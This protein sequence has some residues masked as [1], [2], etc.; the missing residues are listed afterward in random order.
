MKFFSNY[1]FVLSC[2]L[3]IF[4]P[5]QSTLAQLSVTGT[6]YD[7]ETNEPLES[8][9]IVVEGTLTGTSTSAD[10]TFELSVPSE[11][12]VLI[13]SFI[14]FVTQRLSVATDGTDLNIQLVPSIEDIEG[15][16]VVGTRR[17]PRLVTDSSVPIDVISPRDLASTASTD[18]DDILRSQVPSYNVQRHEIDGS[19]TFV[20]PPTLRGLSPD[21]TLLLVNGKR[22]HRTGSIALFGSAL[23][24]GSQGP[25]MNMIPSIAIKQ[26][27]ILRDGASA[28]YGADAV[29]GVFNLQLKDADHGFMVRSQV[30]Q[31]H[32][33]DGRYVTIASNAGFPLT[34]DGFLN[35]SL[36]Y[37]NTE[38]TSRSVDQASATA[39]AN[40]GYPV[41]RPA[42]I[43]GNP[44]ID[45]A[46]TA[47]VNAEIGLTPTTRA[48]AFGGYGQR[49]GNG[50]YFFRMP[51]G[52]TARA[53]VFR[54][55]SGDDAIRAIADLNPGD[56]IDCLTL[57]DLP[58][59]D[60]DFDAVQTFVNQYQGSCY[61][62]N[63]D[64][65]GGFTP[66]FGADISDVSAVVGV[67]GGD[68]SSLMWDISGTVGRS[69]MD[70]FIKNT[71]NASWGPLNP[72]EFRQRDFV[73]LEYSVNVDMSY[74]VEIEG[75]HS[76]LNIA[77][78]AQWRN[79]IFETRPGD[80]LSWSVGPYVQ[81]G[82]YTFS[83][84]SNGDQGIPPA[85]AGRWA[86]PNYAAY[87]DLEADVVPSFQVGVAGRFENFYDDF[88]TTLT[89]KVSALWRT[90]S[91]LSLR[92][93]VST[94]VR[95]PTPGQVNLQN[96]QTNFHPVFGLIDAGQIPSAH[97]IAQAL[98][99]KPLTEESAFNLT[100]GTI[101]QF[102]PDLVLTADLFSITVRDRIALSGSIPLSDELTGI[103]RSSGQ[104]AG[105][106]TLQEVKFYS[107]D[108]D[109]RQFGVDLLLSWDREYGN[110]RSTV[111]SI[112]YNW[113]R[114][115]LLKF[116]D[117]TEITTF[118][119]EPLSEATTVSI[120]S[121]RRKAEI[122]HVN[123]H[124][125]IV[126]TGRQTFGPFHT[127]LR[128]NY[129]SGW[130]ACLLFSF[131][132]TLNIDGR[133]QNVLRSYNGSWIVD[134][135]VGY[136]IRD[137]YGL[138]LGV[139]NIFATHR[140]ADQIERDG[141]GNAM[142]PSTPWDY[143]GASMYLRLSADF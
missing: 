33:G 139:N 95:A 92:G 39:L 24:L 114:P 57:E 67:H 142:V 113:T 28:Q 61:L 60:S 140:D 143:N 25:D 15:L 16:V 102:S 84:G 72:P 66:R 36:E 8:V 3:F 48:Y 59:L 58:P 107:N 117:P 20:R 29:A 88:G 71:V 99:G 46:I 86:R 109:T 42:I 79:E 62:F 101:F 18:I 53:N 70:Y 108:F 43:W 97:P 14:G 69:L 35:V 105:F 120:L 38:P 130:K 123:P 11:D 17:L 56:G 136:R 2:V 115:E 47:F 89:G 6:V 103:L 100:F 68:P 34:D 50:S 81:Q 91:L 78:G 141:Q 83:V 54:F 127:M 76:P 13:V 52:A 65:P 93:S 37:R 119:G 133:T 132:C 104:L 41:K 64:F 128:F 27:E 51:G 49:S 118:L 121:D 90:S 74:P 75:L 87:V 122:E 44:D 131:T 80:S 77:M 137:N 40:K 112:A 125:R 7:S 129:Y 138:A 134:A 12:A 4:I 126:A 135:E 110:G 96:I 98:G 30:G 82:P 26:F 10:G 73:Q 19:T 31:Y 23:I 116:S 1:F 9:T 106:E 32:Q 22:R 21:N 85:Y 63:E 94:G 124:H 55:G 111:A 45:H 5:I